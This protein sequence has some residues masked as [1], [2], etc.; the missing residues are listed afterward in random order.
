MSFTHNSQHKLATEFFFK[1][2]LKRLAVAAQQQAM[3]SPADQLAVLSS[4]PARHG[5]VPSWQHICSVVMTKSVDW[6]VRQVRHYISLINLNGLSDHQHCFNH[7]AVGPR[8]HKRG[9]ALRLSKGEL[10][11]SEK[12]CKVTEMPTSSVEEGYR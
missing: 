3:C 9:E 11:A 6:C 7:A 1:E 8:K 5:K 2:V 4:V 12:I 10:D